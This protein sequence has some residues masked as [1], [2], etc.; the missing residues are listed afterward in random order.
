MGPPTLVTLVG[1]GDE[2]LGPLR[3]GRR[4]VGLAVVAGVGQGHTDAPRGGPVPPAL[5]R[6]VERY[7]TVLQPISRRHCC[8]GRPRLPSERLAR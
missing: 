2:E 8:I 3:L 5:D 4:Q 1:R 6:I 7:D